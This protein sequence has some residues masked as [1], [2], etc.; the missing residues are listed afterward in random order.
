MDLRSELSGG[1]I[2]FVF[3]FKVVAEFLGSLGNH[4]DNA[5]ARY[6]Y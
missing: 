6:A 2:L 5:G 1:F 4:G 3:E